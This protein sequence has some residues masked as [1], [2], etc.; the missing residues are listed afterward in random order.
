MNNT[1]T[2]QP[3]SKNTETY[4]QEELIQKK[5]EGAPFWQVKEDKDFVAVSTE[6]GFVIRS[7]WS[8]KLGIQLQD[9]KED[10][11]YFK[12]EEQAQAVI[13][14][15]IGKG[16][17]N[18]KYWRKVFNPADDFAASEGFNADLINV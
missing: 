1:T 18:M 10:P 11:Q 8:E 9:A 13:A 3:L 14:N 16:W 6:K 7:L 15:V 5:D 4:T 2:T 12:N 17:V